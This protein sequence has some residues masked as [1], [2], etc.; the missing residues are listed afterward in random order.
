L[1]E[2]DLEVHAL[3]ILGVARV[4]QDRTAAERARAPL[5]AAL[6]HTHHRLLL[7]EEASRLA[8]HLLARIAVVRG[9]AAVEGGLDLAVGEPRPPEGVLHLELAGPAEHAVL[10]EHRRAE[11]AARVA[12]GRLHPDLLERSL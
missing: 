11:G 5:H 2:L 3:P 6:E 7:V 9:L 12:R 4:G 10:R 8:D 1:A